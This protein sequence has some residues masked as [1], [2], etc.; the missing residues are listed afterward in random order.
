MKKLMYVSAAL[1]LAIVSSVPAAWAAGRSHEFYGVGPH[2]FNSAANP[3]Y[4][5]IQGA[6]HYF[7]VHVEGRPLLELSIDLPEE[8]D[9]T[10][11]IEVTNESGQ[12]V[13]AQ[14]SV[15]DGKATIAFSQPV[16]PDTTLSINL[17]GVNTPGYSR[18]WIYQVYGRMVG[19]NATIPLG[20]ARIS[21]YGR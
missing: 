6:T 19:L 12:K 3:N 5:R 15:N 17:R 7:Q 1:T 2:I 9:V 13:D 8:V 10:K 16:Q 4:A 14:A 18:H 11:G 21:T 20:P